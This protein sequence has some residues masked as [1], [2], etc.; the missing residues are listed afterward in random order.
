MNDVDSLFPLQMRVGQLSRRELLAALSRSGVRLNASAEVLMN[1]SVFDQQRSET[2]GV[3]CRSV[4]QLGFSEGANLSSIF[5]RAKKLGFSLCP[6]IAA[7]YLRLIWIDQ[8][9]APD[10]V[11]SNGCAPSGSITVA[12]APLDND[13]D[14]PKGFY[15]RTINGILWLRGYHATDKH[16]WSPGDCFAFRER[17]STLQINE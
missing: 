16:V 12:S 3:V 9:S 7:P 5:E 11:M 6:S 15:L 8:E 13:D 4:G 10:N 1:N 17:N 2:F 14:L